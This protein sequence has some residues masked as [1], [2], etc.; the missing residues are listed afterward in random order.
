L[1][2]DVH[3]KYGALTA[4]IY[5]PAEIARL[6]G[7]TPS[8]VRRW[9]FGYHYRV[10][11]DKRD[12]K[13]LPVIRRDS[14]NR[15]RYASFLDLIELLSVK[16]FLDKGLS[17]QRVRRAC[18]EAAAVLKVDHPFARKRFFTA[19]DQI[20]LELHDSLSA[21]NLLQ[22]LSGGQWVIE[23]VIR[24]FAEQI[25]FDLD[26][27]LASK[28]WPLGKNEHVVLDPL[29]SFGAPSI[30]GRGV[31]TSNVFDLYLAERGRAEIVAPWMSLTIAEVEAAVRFEKMQLGQAA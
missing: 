8:R 19:G 20:Y 1:A 22:L 11:I 2:L 30:V 31:K 26:S 14:S 21:A 28:W 17:L 3:A 13:Q 23:P 4:P 7:L 10:G 12:K 27:D 25:D 9:L 15:Y 6:V 16:S 5:E 29:V 24:G 18:D